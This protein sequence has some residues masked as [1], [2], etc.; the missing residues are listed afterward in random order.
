MNA[1]DPHTIVRGY[2]PTDRPGYLELMEAVFGRP[3]LHNDYAAT[4]DRVLGA[5]AAVVR[6]AERA[7]SVVGAATGG[8]DGSR[9]WLYAVAVAPDVRRARLGTRLVRAVEEALIERGCPKV[10]LQ[11]RAGN[12]P[13]VAFYESLGYAVEPRVSLGKRLG[14]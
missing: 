4:L 9:G 13:V 5:G 11:V 3:A 1:A 6:I 14:V 2:R 8:Y 10:N 7:G 12:E